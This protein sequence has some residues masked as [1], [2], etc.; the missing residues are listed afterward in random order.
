MNLEETLSKVFENAIK[1]EVSN[2][3][4]PDEKSLELME[5]LNIPY[6]VDSVKISDLYVILT[7]NKKMEKIFSLLKL[8]H[9]W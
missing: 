7:D 6:S 9:F 1:E 8:K 3:E 4:I 2:G 5:M